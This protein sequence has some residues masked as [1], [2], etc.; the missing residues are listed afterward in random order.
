MGANISH[1]GPAGAGQHCKMANQ[2]A[3][4]VGMIAWTEALA[5]ARSAGL[6]PQKVLASISGGAA[7]SWSMTN[8]APRALAGNFA[9]GFY[10]KHIRKDIGIAIASAAEMGLDVPGLACARALYD[11][12]AGKGWEEMGTQVLYRLYTSL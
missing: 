7:G 8:L 12:V 3:V 11:R 5:Y 1:L 4:A 9:P 2:I 6:D 10:V